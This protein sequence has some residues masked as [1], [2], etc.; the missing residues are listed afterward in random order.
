MQN[1]LGELHRR[2]DFKEPFLFVNTETPKWINTIKGDAQNNYFPAKDF[3]EKEIPRYF[4]DFAFVQSLILPEVEIN[5]V[6][7]EYNRFF[8]NQQQQTY[9]TLL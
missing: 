9:I 7:G 2:K 1:K 6:V 4:G 8:V 3:F 5:E